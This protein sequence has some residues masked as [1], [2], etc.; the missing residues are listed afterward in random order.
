[1]LF[2]GYFLFIIFF[3]EIAAEVCQ[4]LGEYPQL[5]TMVFRK[6]DSGP[7][8]RHHAILVI[9]RYQIICLRRSA[10]KV[11]IYSF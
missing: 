11:C 7:S 4:D 1:L 6:K 9:S 5:Q 3:I 10:P 2:I 8:N